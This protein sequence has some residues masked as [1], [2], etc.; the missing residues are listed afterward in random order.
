[1]RRLSDREGNW[2][3]R[4][5]AQMSELR[6]KNEEATCTAA[7][8]RPII[9]AASICRSYSRNGARATRATRRFLE[10]GIR[11]TSPSR[12][13]TTSA[14]EFGTPAHATQNRQ[15]IPQFF[16]ERICCPVMILTIQG[17][18]QARTL[19]RN[20]PLF[21]QIPNDSRRSI[22][23]HPR[24]AIRADNRRFLPRKFRENRS[25]DAKP[26]N[27]TPLFSWKISCL[28]GIMGETC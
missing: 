24:I 5:C 1:M 15:R 7:F 25:Y 27:H 3:N 10:E 18:I 20:L 21:P 17:T 23:E 13:G 28:A 11:I 26:L 9:E 6:R 16:E 2:S 19:G 14:K 22:G 12:L 4:N 8:E